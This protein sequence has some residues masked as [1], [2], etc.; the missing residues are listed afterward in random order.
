MMC[1]IGHLL[2]MLVLLDIIIHMKKILSTGIAWS[3]DFHGQLLY[4]FLLYA[5]C[6]KHIRFG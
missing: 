2:H 3:D 4:I 5:V 1:F 6:E